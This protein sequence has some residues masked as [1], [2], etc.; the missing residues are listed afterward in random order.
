MW[1]GIGCPEF[2]IARNTM[3][4][5]YNQT[6]F[7]VGLYFS[8]VLSLVIILKMFLTFYIKKWGAVYNCK[9]SSKPWRAAQTHTVFLAFTF[10]AFFGV[11][12]LYG[13]IL[14]S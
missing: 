5:I 8:P 13:Y 7:Y 2:D 11:I 6:L 4:L 3:N 12:V 10:L 9:P 1:K 14:T